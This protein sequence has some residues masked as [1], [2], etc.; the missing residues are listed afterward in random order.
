MQPLAVPPAD[1]RGR[2]LAAPLLF[3]LG[4]ALLGG[5]ATRPPAE[6]SRLPQGELAGAASWY[7]HQYH[8]KRTA[9][10]EVYD[11]DSMTAAHRTLPFNSQV[12]VQRTDTGGAVEVRINDRGPFVDGRVIDLSRAAARRLGMENQGLAPVRLTP[13]EVPEE[14]AARWSIVVGGLSHAR[15]DRLA[16]RLREAGPQLPQ[17]IYR[18]NGD[19]R[20]AQVWLRGYPREAAARQVVDR[21][22]GEGYPAFLVRT[23]R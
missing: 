11:M 16:A 10:G 3:V 9:N 1:R 17:V 14:A 15:I 8:G 19:R 7:G 20:F 21:L 23:N 4:L 5:C 22:R 2:R 13:L 18:W 6:V 12:R